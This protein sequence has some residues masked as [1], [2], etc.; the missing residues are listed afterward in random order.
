M[1]LFIQN[2]QQKATLMGSRLAVAWDSGWVGMK[3]DQI[4]AWTAF[5]EGEMF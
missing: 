1:I 4:W 2:V 5:R 3:N